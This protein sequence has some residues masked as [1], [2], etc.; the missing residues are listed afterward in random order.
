M[1]TDATASTL[2]SPG[3]YLR[4][5]WEIVSKIGGGGFGEIYK[6]LDHSTELVSGAQE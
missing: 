3:T 4:E 1:E 6:A 2:L 5:R